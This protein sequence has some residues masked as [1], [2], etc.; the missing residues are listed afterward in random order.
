MRLEGWEVR[1]ADYLDR[2]TFKKFKWGECDCLIFAADCVL[3]L[4]GIDVM[5]K[6]KRNDPPTIRGMYETE[7]EAKTLIKKYRKS[8][9]DIMDVHFDR[10]SVNFAK[11]GDVVMY[12]NAFG[13]CSGQ[14]FAFFKDRDHKITLVKLS[15]CKV[16]WDI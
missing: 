13:I 12:K 4:T 14:G 15:E 8:I 16:V 2:A 6:K 9:R 1:F 3:V 11:R 7:E 5:A 10:K